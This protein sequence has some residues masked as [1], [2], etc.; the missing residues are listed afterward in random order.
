MDG[1]TELSADAESSSEAAGVDDGSERTDP[2]SPDEPESAANGETP[3]DF[4]R[5]VWLASHRSG[6]FRHSAS[7]VA[8]LATDV[9]ATWNAGWAVAPGELR[10][11]FPPPERE[12]DWA[13]LHFTNWQERG[14]ILV[15]REI[16]LSIL[17]HLL[18]DPTIEI[19]PPRTLSALE[20]SV[21]ELIVEPLV[22]LTTSQLL[23]G[24]GTKIVHVEGREAALSSATPDLTFL[25]LVVDTGSHQGNIEI[26][27]PTVTLQTF[28]EFVDRRQAGARSRTEGRFSPQA[29]R[30]LG[31]V[32]LEAIVQF[33]SFPVSAPVVSHLKSGDVLRTGH[34]VHRPLTAVIGGKPLYR[35]EAGQRGDRLVVEVVDVVSQPSK[36]LL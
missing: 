2:G 29:V 35:V 30:A 5:S 23:L 13:L 25:V 14:L 15:D 16:S 6:A 4:G 18:G 3:H 10:V 32:S 1:S 36:G 17:V 12:V 21:I 31:A 33:D 24:G 19:G 11:G 9:M 27:L 20:Y 34:P 22:D 7:E 8:R 26:G 28:A